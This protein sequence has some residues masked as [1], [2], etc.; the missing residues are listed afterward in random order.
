MNSW[1][2]VGKVGKDAVIRKAGAND[3]VSFPLASDSGYGDRKK[4]TWVDCSFW[5]QRAVKVADYIRKG[6][7][8]GVTGEVSTRDHE[9][10]TFVTLNVTDV[11]LLGEKREAAPRQE[12]KPAPQPQSTGA[13]F[14]DEEIPF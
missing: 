3:V 2:V 14:Q 9:G 10:K 6:D 4:T 7:R 13:P 1:S 12:A 8:I 11:T 5:G